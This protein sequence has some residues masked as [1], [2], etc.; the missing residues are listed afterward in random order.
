MSEKFAQVHADFVAEFRAADSALRQHITT[1]TAINHAELARSLEETR[2]NMTEQGNKLRQEAADE[3]IMSRQV[4][5]QQARVNRREIAKYNGSLK[6]V[7]KLEHNQTRSDLHKQIRMSRHQEIEAA[8]RSHFVSSLKFPEMNA[9]RNQIVAPHS[10]TFDWIFN[11]T[12][13]RP[14]DSLKEFLKTPSSI[15]WIN[16]KAGSGKSSLMRYICTHD[17]CQQM[18]DTWSGP[19]K[20]L[21]ISWYFWNSGTE[22]QKSL[23]GALCSL[24]HQILSQDHA[25]ASKLFQIHNPN[26][27]TFGK[28]SAT[29]WSL[30][31][32][33]LLFEAALRSVQ[34][35]VMIFLDGLDEFNDDEDIIRLLLLIQKAA[36]QPRVKACVSSRPE[37]Y[38]VS[39]LELYPQLKLQDLT[40]NDI[41]TVVVD[42]LKACASHWEDSDIQ[43]LAEKVR[44][45]ASGVFLW[46]RLVTDQLVR[47]LLHGDSQQILMERLTKLSPKMEAL[48][49]HMWRSLNGDDNLESYQQQAAKCLAFLPIFP[50]TVFELVVSLD[51]GLQHTFIEAIHD[52]TEIKQLLEKCLA[53]EDLLKTRCAGLL[54]ISSDPD[55]EVS[56][57]GSM[58]YKQNYRNSN[59]TRFGSKKS[60]TLVYVGK[61]ILRDSVS[62]LADESPSSDALLGFLTRIGAMEINF[63]HRSAKDFL[64]ESTI[65]RQVRQHCTWTPMDVLNRVVNAYLQR[66]IL[67]FCALT[68]SGSRYIDLDRLAS[69]I[70]GITNPS[71]TIVSRQYSLIKSIDFVYQ[72]L[73]DS[74]RVVSRSDWQKNWYIHSSERRNGYRLDFW[75]AIA[76]HFSVQICD[77]V[78]SNGPGDAMLATYFLASIC[79]EGDFD[80]IDLRNLHAMQAFLAHGADSNS[81]SMYTHRDDGQVTP[82]LRFL[83]LASRTTDYSGMEEELISTIEAFRASG[84]ELS[85]VAAIARHPAS[86]EF[87]CFDALMTENFHKIGEVVFEV[88]AAYFLDKIRSKI[89]DPIL[90]CRVKGMLELATP[91]RMVALVRG[92][93]GRWFTVDPDDAVDYLEKVVDNEVEVTASDFAQYARKATRNGVMVKPRP[94]LAARRSVAAYDRAKSFQGLEHLRQAS[95]RTRA[96]LTVS[97]LASTWTTMGITSELVNGFSEITHRRRGATRF[98]SLEDMSNHLA[99]FLE[100]H[101]PLYLCAPDKDELYSMLSEIWEGLVLVGKEEAAKLDGEQLE[102]FNEDLDELYRL[103]HEHGLEHALASRDVGVE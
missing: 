42:R 91:Y 1:E 22:F 26:V 30:A 14:W 49:E 33:I 9:R 11:N 70:F 64:L 51:D 31:E 6:R 29:D 77:L 74:E 20:T 13:D 15:Y 2:R 50:M 19:G 87:G 75:G 73:V 93:N 72:T 59:S 78:L 83:R 23:R 63:I 17:T 43:K 28:E 57:L 24:S 58:A 92:V 90:A 60:G 54:E 34:N 46:V 47:G 96:G 71:P 25:L 65:G 18:L 27:T 86:G 56:G 61:S 32:L 76:T 79:W 100:L 81:V 5:I 89:Q 85:A 12:I 53:I 66:K 95:A 88:N 98:T 4:I 41:R 40:A 48:Y 16:G 39:R 84:A 10:Q 35:H 82:W 37:K 94:F 21:I 102:S 55:V 67:G 101:G 7:V 36:Q 45:R 44:D 97:W 8:Q 99:S 38:L 103:F 68:D 80:V 3:G 69:L 52:A 62:V